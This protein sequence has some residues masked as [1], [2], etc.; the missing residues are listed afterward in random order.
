MTEPTAIPP[1]DIDTIRAE[2]QRRWKES[3]QQQ[4]GLLSLIEKSVPGWLILIAA[5]MYLLSAPHTAGMFDKITPGWG[6]VAP[7]GVEFALVY[8]AFRR[9]RSERRHL[10]T[11]FTLWAMVV[12]MFVTSIAV[13]GAGALSAAVTTTGIQDYSLS[14]IHEKF[15]TLPVL[16]QVALALVALAA[17]IIPLGT[18]V[19]GEGLAALFYDRD[20]AIDD[21][22]KRWVE[23]EFH[24]LRKAFF[25]AYMRAGMRSGDAKRQASVVASGFVEASTA[26]R[27]QLSAGAEIRALPEPSTVSAMDTPRIVRSQSRTK[28]TPAAVDARANVRRYLD[29][30]PEASAMSVR[31]L[32]SAVGVSKSLAAEELS[33]WKEAHNDHSDQA[34]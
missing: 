28:K 29:G 7:L 25:T 3:N 9:K 19:A 26:E 5:V 16:T 34:L 8:A 14:Q 2:T 27:P 30:H 33:K 18:T 13:N 1:I 20:V 24:E 11:P 6:W 32:A 23:V 21:L 12:L 15:G 31:Q 4:R 22:D 17:L 10:R